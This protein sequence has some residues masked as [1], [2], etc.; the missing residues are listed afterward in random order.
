M[1]G[2]VG[3]LL[4]RVKVNPK[5]LNPDCKNLSNMFRLSAESIQLVSDETSV[6]TYGSFR[7]PLSHRTS[8][9]HILAG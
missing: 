4:G 2:G 1:E 6:K 8:V 7:N 3:Y 5:P 9:S